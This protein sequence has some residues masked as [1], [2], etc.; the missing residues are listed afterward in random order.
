MQTNACKYGCDCNYRIDKLHQKAG[1]AVNGYR[2]GN[3]VNINQNNAN[4]HNDNRAW[5]GS[6]KVYWLYVDFSH[7][8]TIF[9]ISSNFA[10][11]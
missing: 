11:S 4:N 3:D 1:N 6:L 2:N 8:P 5:R 7:P 10:C 9:P